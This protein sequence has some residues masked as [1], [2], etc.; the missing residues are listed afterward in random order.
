VSQQ[1]AILP[2][3]ASGATIMTAALSMSGP[4]ARPL[5]AIATPTSSG[6]RLEGR[7]PDVPWAAEARII[8]TPVRL[9]GAGRSAVF[10]V[11]NDAE[12]VTVVR[13]SNSTEGDVRLLG[14]PVTEYDRIGGNAGNGAVADM[15]FRATVGVC[16]LQLG[17]CEQ[18][19]DLLVTYVKERHQFGR[20]IASFQAVGHQAAN[21][22]I[23]LEAMRLTLW[24]A[25]WQLD[26]GIDAAASVAVAKYWAARGA[27][28]ILHT[29]IH[30][31]G[32]A[33]MDR[34]YPLPRYFDV[35]SQLGSTMGSADAQLR[36]LG[37]WL[38]GL[39]ADEGNQLTTDNQPDVRLI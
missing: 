35:S 39:V 2:D 36:F 22:Y 28:R 3:V 27:H 19:L 23:D 4:V 6:W 14:V 12:G 33:G 29:A 5:P 11:R 17:L 8:V 24:Q 9:A 32:G 26:A 30:L 21:A 20:P 37:G 15:R 7:L 10:A 38:R 1:Q 13:S 16:A 31:H 25:A 34:A 18:V